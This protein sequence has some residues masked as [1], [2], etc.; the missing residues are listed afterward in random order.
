MEG[1]GAPVYQPSSV[2]VLSFILSKATI[3]NKES[4]YSDDDDESGMEKERVG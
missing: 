1:K 3:L 2:P 4:R